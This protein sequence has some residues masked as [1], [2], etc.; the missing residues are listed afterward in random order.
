MRL[1]DC[2]RKLLRISSPPSWCIQ[3]RCGISRGQWAVVVK[4]RA[5]LHSRFRLAEDGI[6][7]APSTPIK[8]ATTR[9][10]PM[11]PYPMSCRRLPCPGTRQSCRCA[12]Q[13][14]V[15]TGTAPGRSGRA[16][17]CRGRGGQD[18]GHVTVAK[19]R[20]WGQECQDEL[21]A[22]EGGVDAR[23]ETVQGLFCD[24]DCFVCR[25]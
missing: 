9:M 19:I 11:I 15:S 6:D 8:S 20:A 7:N 13:R 22:E 1:S 12:A 21:I 25:L 3:A 14:R 5:G 18:G 4:A 16:A 17:R 2:P 10:A 23:L 24:C